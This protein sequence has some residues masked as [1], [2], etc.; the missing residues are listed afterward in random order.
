MTN[1][2]RSLWEDMPSSPILPNVE[3]SSPSTKDYVDF[4]TSRKNKPLRRS[5]EWACATARLSG[6]TAPHPPL[7]DED[8]D[9]TIRFAPPPRWGG[10]ED[11]DVDSICSEQH[12]AITPDCSQASIDVFIPKSNPS[13]SRQSLMNVDADERKAESDIMDAA[14]ALCGL[15]QMS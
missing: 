7:E 12:E 8:E 3:P 15:S 9:A 13:L 1:P 5:L 10:D 4:A 14:W 2:K 11:T 6:K